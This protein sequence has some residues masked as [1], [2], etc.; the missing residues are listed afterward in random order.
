MLG[1][2][3]VADNLK[4][5]IRRLY[6]KCA[7][8]YRNFQARRYFKKAEDYKKEYCGGTLMTGVYSKY[9]TGYFYLVRE[10]THKRLGVKK[11]QGE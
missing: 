4:R 8:P 7:Q 10:G 2:K 11:S 6:F 5:L 9:L 3:N 1:R